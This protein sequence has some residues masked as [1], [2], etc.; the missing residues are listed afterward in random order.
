MFDPS[1]ADLGH[2]MTVYEAAWGGGGGQVSKSMFTVWTNCREILNNLAIQP[3]LNSM[4]SQY[5]LY[6]Y[7]HCYL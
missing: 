6:E 2:I 4:H 1:T 3:F 7:L 5:L